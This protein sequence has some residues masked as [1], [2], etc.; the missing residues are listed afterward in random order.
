MSQLK[1]H[2]E[3][4][5]AFPTSLDAA[6]QTTD[7][8]RWFLQPVRCVDPNFA[9]DVPL[10]HL[11]KRVS[12]SPS[13]ERPLQPVARFQ[14]QRRNARAEVAATKLPHEVHA[15]D[16]L[17]A[18]LKARPCEILQQRTLRTP[19][20]QR[21]DILYLD[22]TAA[23]GRPR[24]R[25][26]AIKHNDLL[27]V[28]RITATEAD[29]NSLAADILIQ[30]AGFCV[31]TD[32]RS[33]YAEEIVPFQT[34]RLPFRF[35]YPRSWRLFGLPPRDG[36]IGLR[37][38]RQVQDRVA[39]GIQ[40]AFARPSL[41]GATADPWQETLASLALQGI[42]VTAEPQPTPGTRWTESGLCIEGEDASGRQSGRCERLRHGGGSVCLSMLGPSRTTDPA[43]WAVNRRA[44]EIIRDSIQ[45][46]Y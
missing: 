15:S 31:E 16:W 29:Y 37:L 39:G 40:L 9:C 24:T 19:L 23:Q 10:N 44:F 7:D 38:T 42:D 32:A 27:L 18:V 17:E 36:L 13:N 26:T 41:P 20:G 33:M 12:V 21:P 34:Q 35:A 3:R 4:R 46:A 14:H 45:V 28:L 30:L 2:D 8:R 43:N 5:P 25:A 1:Q 11:W 6:I 22:Q